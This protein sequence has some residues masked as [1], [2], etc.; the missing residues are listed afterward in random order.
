MIWFTIFLL[1]IPCA[2]IAVAALLVWLGTG[3][4]LALLNCVEKSL[5]NFT[6]GH[7]IFALLYLVPTALLLCAL[8]QGFCLTYSFV[9][10]VLLR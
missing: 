5:T 10:T 4:I 1:G 3:A 7:V 2:V 8:V 9:T 6:D